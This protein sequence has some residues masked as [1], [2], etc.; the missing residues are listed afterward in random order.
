MYGTIARM[1]VAK[2]KEQAFREFADS[3]GREGGARRPAGMKFDYLYQ[4]DADPN[5]YYLVVGFESRE[6][7]HA[8]AQSPEQHEQ[9]LSMREWMAAEPEWHD[10]E[11]VFSNIV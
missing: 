5:E 1:R 8:N 10:G 3:I 6:A 7:Y 9:Y 11:I 4:S 2:G